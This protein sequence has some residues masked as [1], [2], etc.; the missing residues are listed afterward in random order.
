[1]LPRIVGGGQSDHF[2]VFEM[3]MR[4]RWNNKEQVSGKHPPLESVDPVSEEAVFAA[5]LLLVSIMTYKQPRSSLVSM[6]RRIHQ[7]RRCMQADFSSLCWQSQDGH[8]VLPAGNAIK[9]SSS[10]RQSSLDCR[11]QYIHK[12]LAAQ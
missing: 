12:S 7:A 4:G 9:Q 6:Q 1:M 8:S 5:N 3:I 10:P 11:F 2:D